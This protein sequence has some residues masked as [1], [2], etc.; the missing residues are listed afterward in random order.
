M[1]RS[2]IRELMFL[3]EGEKPFGLT[4]DR[5]AGPTGQESGGAWMVWAQAGSSGKGPLFSQI[6]LGSL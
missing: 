6:E 4:E 2:V 3:V 1:V 5:A